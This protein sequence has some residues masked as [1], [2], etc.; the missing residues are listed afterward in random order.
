[1]P[2]ISNKVKLT[3]KRGEKNGDE[4]GTLT[5]NSYRHPTKKLTKPVNQRSLQ[6]HL[7]TDLYET[8]TRWL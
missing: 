1:M 5:K 2:L 4:L 7:E 8:E 3:P 6:D